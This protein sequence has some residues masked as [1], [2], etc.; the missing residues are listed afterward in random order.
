MYVQTEDEAHFRDSINAFKQVLFIHD[1]S[2]D[3]TIRD[4]SFM[5][6]RRQELKLV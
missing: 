2:D 5:N 6:V 1:F 4:Y 3:K